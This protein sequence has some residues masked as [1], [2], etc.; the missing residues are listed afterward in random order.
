MPRVRHFFLLIWGLI[1]ILGAVALAFVT[2][3]INLT[4]KVNGFWLVVAAG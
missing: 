3:V 2:G 1:A 4:E